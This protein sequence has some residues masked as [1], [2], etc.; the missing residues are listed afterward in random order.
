M[1]VNIVIVVSS[2]LCIDRKRLIFEYLLGVSMCVCVYDPQVLELTQAHQ[3]NPIKP[4]SL[5]WSEI[6]ENGSVSKYKKQRERKRR[7]GHEGHAWC[8][9]VS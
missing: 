6:E 5:Y 4:S 3:R 1:Y 7:D 2:L 8:I 9:D